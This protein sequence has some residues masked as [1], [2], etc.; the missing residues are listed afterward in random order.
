VDGNNMP[1][2]EAKGP[3]FFAEGKIEVGGKLSATAEFSF[4]IMK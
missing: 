3:F 4:A 1:Y 2:I